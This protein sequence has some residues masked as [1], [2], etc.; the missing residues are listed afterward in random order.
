MQRPQSTEHNEYF[1]KYIGLLP[2]GDYFDLLMQNTEDVVSSFAS[3]SEEKQNYRYAP[4]KW[5]P[6]QMLMHLIDMERGMSLIQTLDE[7]LYAANAVVDHRSMDDLLE[8]FA[9]VRF[10][11]RKLFEGMT[12]EQTTWTANVTNGRVSARALGYMMIGHAIHH[13]NVLKERYL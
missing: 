8:E 6:K 1:L 7:D 13:M 5:T 4:G 2:E 11:T 10:T 12:E 9:A 3:L